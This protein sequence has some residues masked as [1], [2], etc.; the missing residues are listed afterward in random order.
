MK[1]TEIL[2]RCRESTEEIQRL[3]R[4]LARLERCAEASASIGEDITHCKQALETRRRAQD[5]EVAAACRIVDAL[6]D[7]QCGILYRY[8]V[9]G[10]SQGAI[11]EAMHYTT[12]YYKRK[13]KE[14][15]AIAEKM[16]EAVVDA[17]LPDW[18][19]AAEKKR[20]V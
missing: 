9:G 12:R 17:L 8:F 2:T 1:A 15:L 19:L 6:P 5:V 7:P 13:K 10:Q 20:H 4:R 14:G 16:D 18:Y 3:Q 11:T